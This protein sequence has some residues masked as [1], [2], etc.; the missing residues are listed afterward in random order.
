[1]STQVQPQPICKTPGCTRAGRRVRDW[2]Q[3]CYVRQ[4][5]NGL[6]LLGRRG[7]LPS[8]EVPEGETSPARIGRLLGISRQRAHQI[9]NRQEN[10]ARI[11][12]GYAE[13]MG[14]ITKP[15]ICQHCFKETDDL[16]K[17]HPNYKKPLHVVWVCSLC[18]SAV[19]PHHP[20]SKGLRQEIYRNLTTSSSLDR[21][22]RD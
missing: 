21:T 6:Q 18:H 22:Q 14:Q 11:K 3:A 4:L 2:C 13:R 8:V 12:A 19:H 10:S 16:E 1:M 9:L 7:P 17:H 5:R 20:Y 15:L